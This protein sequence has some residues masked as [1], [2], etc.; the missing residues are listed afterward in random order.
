LRKVIMSA[1]IP[2]RKLGSTNLDVT[3]LGY[4][5]MEI[6]GSRIWDGRSISDKQAET[7]LN[8]V[9]DSGINFIDT[10][11]DYGRSEDLIGRYL[12]DRR[13]E[14]YL[15]TKCGCSVTRKDEYT[16]DT[17]H[18]WTRQNLYRGL[19]E[20]LR[21]LRTDHVDL[22]QLH[23]PKV[24]QCKTGDL[25]RV[26]ED[27]RKEGSV[28]WIGCSSTLPDIL[29]YIEWGVFDTF[30]IP[31]SALER[32]HEDIIR[33]AA[34]SGAGVIVRGGVARGEPT[35]GLGTEA[36]WAKFGDVRLDNLRDPGESRTAFLL[37]FTLSHPDISTVI[38]GTLRPEHLVENVSA[39]ARGPLSEDTYA[40]AKSRLGGVGRRAPTG[41]EKEVA[42]LHYKSAGLAPATAT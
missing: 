32:Q 40:E 15:A 41:L 2:K 13:D 30:Q 36:F 26:L 35:V 38:V 28:R 42:N 29:T 6:R 21:R 14:F 17:P 37:R 18:I 22:M 39:V 5:A 25:V 27:M 12:G 8:A 4:G 10:A 19:H 34:L 33:R 3:C 1:A 9:L 11:N 24:E 7:I 23:N 20:S 16:D 31:Y